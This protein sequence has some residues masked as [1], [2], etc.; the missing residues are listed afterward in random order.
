MLASW[1]CGKNSNR[2]LA[3]ELGFSRTP[4]K[5]EMNTEKEGGFNLTL[6]IWHDSFR[7]AQAAAKRKGKPVLTCF[8]GSD[9][10][11][12]CVKLKEDIFDQEEFEQWASENVV[13]CELDYPRG[14]MQNPTI[15]AANAQLKSK[16][17]IQG[18]PTVLIIN[19]DGAVMAKSGY[20]KDVSEWIAGI[21]GQMR[22]FEMNSKTEF[23][24]EKPT[25]VR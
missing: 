15:K 16:Y 5:L 2:E 6:T 1:G 9:W 14:T 8:T 17:N 19:E 23:V 21:E 7:A 24:S 12:W 3:K 25:T 11:H 13:L 22:Q 18:F 10:C 4:E 20:G